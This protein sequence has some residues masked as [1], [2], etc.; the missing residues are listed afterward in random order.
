MAEQLL[1]KHQGPND[2][3]DPGDLTT[4]TATLLTLMQTL[5]EGY[6]KLLA[7]NEQRHDAL[8]A[9]SV[10]KLRELAEQ[11]RQLL[12][13]L[14]ECEKQRLQVAASMTLLFD[15][16]AKRPWR[17]SELA[18]HLPASMAK[19]VTETRD[20]LKQACLSLQKRQSVTQAATNRMLQHATGLIQNLCQL[21]SQTATYDRP[22]S[23][24]SRQRRTG[25]EPTAMLHSSLNLTA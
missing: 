4:H 20:A 14:S 3:G 15:A 10:T 17:V 22:D 2:P 6:G 13:G 7:M 21:V 16:K 11:E 1:K 12:R 18:E 24:A 19:R 23:P 9:A 8:R 25:V 5:T